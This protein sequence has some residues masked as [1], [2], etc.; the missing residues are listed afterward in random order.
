MKPERTNIAAASDVHTHSGLLFVV[1]FG[2]AFSA[3]VI[4][5]Q[6]TGRA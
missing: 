4:S 2:I 6:S 3:F 5:A 1:S